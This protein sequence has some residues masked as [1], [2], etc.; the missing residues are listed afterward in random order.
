MYHGKHYQAAKRLLI[1]GLLGAGL[2]LT[3]VSWA[4]TTPAPGTTFTNPASISVQGSGSTV[5]VPDAFSLTLI[6][7][8]RGQTVTKLNQQISHDAEQL[9]SF[10]QEQG[11]EAK[12]IQSMQVQL[13]PWYEHTP[14]GREHQ[15]FVLSREI[16]VTH[17]QIDGY[18][19]LIDG[20]LKRGVTRIGSFHLFAQNQQQ[21]YEQAL[22]NAVSNA[23]STAT[24]L[25]EQLDAEL[26]KVL[27]I[28]QQ[29]QGMPQPVASARMHM[30]T[31][32]AAM[33]G[34][35]QIDA[36]VQVTFALH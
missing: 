15:G 4:Q 3:S 21:A 17:N 12:H 36:T 8:Q 30:A 1:S 5:V 2:A 24:L 34:Q 14:N 29:P 31:E 28:T 33:P 22:I 19:T 27:H 23:K 32:S 6:L 20:A 16:Q 35:Q 13:H 11:V 9:V 7:E 26:G 10:L 25:V 18:D